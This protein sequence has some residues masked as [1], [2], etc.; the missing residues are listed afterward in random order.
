M[1]KIIFFA[2][3]TLL[4]FV[5]QPEARA[6]FA[7]A[8]AKT[9][10]GVDGV[11]VTNAGTGTLIAVQ[12]FAHSAC[13]AQLTVTK[14]FRTI[15]G[16]IKVRGRNTVDSPSFNIPSATIALSDATA[17][18]ATPCSYQFTAPLSYRYIEF[19]ASGGTTVVYRVRGS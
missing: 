1:K 7:T 2:V 13:N 10:A 16:D 8:M 15:A 12:T 18:V 14:T 5:L 11:V 4:G 19:Y 17:G 9:S 6:Q 3:F